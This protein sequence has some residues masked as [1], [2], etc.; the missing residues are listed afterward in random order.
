M[1]R[2]GRLVSGGEKGP[3]ELLVFFSVSDMMMR[4]S[5]CVMKDTSRC[6]LVAPSTWCSLKTSDDRF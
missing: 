4:D 2:L 5:P 3:G 1:F 6:S